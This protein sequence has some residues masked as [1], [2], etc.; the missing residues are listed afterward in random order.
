M[1][2]IIIN[3]KDRYKQLV[4]SA[5]WKNFVFFDFKNLD[6]IEDEK[7][8]FRA[9]TQLRMPNGIYKTTKANRFIDIDEELISIL[10]E[11]KTYLIHDVAASDGITSVELLQKLD[12]SNIKSKFIFSDKFAKIFWSPKWYGTVYKD[13]E[14]TVLFLD[15]FGIQA[16]RNT[17]IKY[18]FSK[19]LGYLFPGNSPVLNSDTEILLLNPKAREAI[20][21]GKLEFMYY[22]IF[23]SKQEKE[24]F[25]L[26]RCINILNLGVFSDELISK[27]LANLIPSLKE[28]GIF[29]IGRSDESNFV[30][31]ATIYKKTGGK[32]L[33]M[34]NINKGTELKN[35]I[36]KINS[37]N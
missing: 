34:K 35:L 11:N 20:S 12:K 26:I 14:G 16:Y 5:I 7:L 4:Q 10:E 33:P 27:G 36:D 29:L 30:N 18:I 23:E 17:S 6:T 32:L 37:V 15:F 21:E 28:G 2:K 1:I 24:K 22:D 3:N 13:Q 31:H 19:I 8:F 25:D 9:I